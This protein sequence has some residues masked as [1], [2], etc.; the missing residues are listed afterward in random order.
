MPL[1]V[2]RDIRKIYA[3]LNADTI[4]GEAWQD[5]NVGLL[6]TSESTL[7]RM[8][9]FLAPPF[10]DGV[11]RTQALRSLHPSNGNANRFDFVLCEPGIPVPRNGYLFESDE[12]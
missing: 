6:A 2:L 5:L 1:N 10:M 7:R 4:R 12:S 11:A 9:D 8:E 3:G